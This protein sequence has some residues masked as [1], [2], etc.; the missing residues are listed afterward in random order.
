L[1]S[2]GLAALLVLAYGVVFTGFWDDLVAD[3]YAAFNRPP[4]PTFAGWQMKAVVLLAITVGVLMFW[5]PAIVRWWRVRRRKPFT[6]AVGSLSHD[7]LEAIRT[8]LDGLANTVAAQGRGIADLTINKDEIAKISAAMPQLE[9][10]ASASARKL[11]IVRQALSLNLYFALAQ[12]NFIRMGLLIDLAPR[13]DAELTAE[14]YTEVQKY[15]ARLRATELG[16]DRHFIL[17]SHIETAKELVEVELR[18][19][20]AALAP[21]EISVHDWREWLIAQRQCGNAVQY[22]GAA[23]KELESQLAADYH[24]K[25]NEYYTAIERGED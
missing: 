21:A 14:W 2:A 24:S 3:V 9:H 6:R 8:T 18:T 19:G 17:M 5:R 23:R 16:A 1:A 25:L 11:G 7:H 20:E 22:L 13:P 4:P 10:S 12:T 15:L